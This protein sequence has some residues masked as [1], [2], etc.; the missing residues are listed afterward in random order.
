MLEDDFETLQAQNPGMQLQTKEREEQKA[1]QTVVFRIHWGE[2][3]RL[4]GRKKEQLGELR[5]EL[6]KITG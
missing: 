5:A 4:M 6:R 1:E 2:N 3:E